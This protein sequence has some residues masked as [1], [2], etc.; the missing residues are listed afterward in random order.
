MTPAEAPGTIDGQ[1]EIR[2][3]RQIPIIKSGLILFKIL[4]CRPIFG[5]AFVFR[6]AYYRKEFSV[7][8]TFG[9]Y[10]EGNYVL[11]LTRPKFTMTLDFASFV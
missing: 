11:Y 6:R 2:I 7:S 5:R 9:L 1:P 3:C 8:K 4:F 10:F